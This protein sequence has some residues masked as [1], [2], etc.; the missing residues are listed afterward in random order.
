M[1]FE[2]TELKEVLAE[3]VQCEVEFFWE[4]CVR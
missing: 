4:V 2:L 1:C 3:E